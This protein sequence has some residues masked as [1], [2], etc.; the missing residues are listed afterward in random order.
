ME[1]FA[2]N[3]RP[4]ARASRLLY[5]R[6]GLRLLL[7]TI[8]VWLV[9]GAI[10]W[11]VGRS[12]ELGIHPVDSLFLVVLTSFFLL[13]PAAPGYIGTFDAALLFGL[14]ALHVRGG[15]ALGFVLLARF[16]LFVPITLA[17]I[18][19]LFARYGGLFHVRSVSADGS[20]T[21]RRTRRGLRMAM[22]A[23]RSAATRSDES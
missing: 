14:T 1:R 23:R 13:V 4:F 9:E 15:E 6:V 12:L 8:G 19:L 11:L 3:V 22:V 2:A 18:V 21:R 17:G 16:V 10:F 20:N 7:L 5:G